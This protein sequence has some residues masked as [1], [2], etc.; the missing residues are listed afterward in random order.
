[1]QSAQLLPDRRLVARQL[2]GEVEHL[3]GGHEADAGDE[4]QHEQ[5]R[6]RDGK[7]ENLHAR[8]KL[9]RGYGAGGALLPKKQLLGAPWRVAFALQADG[10]VLR[11]DI[12]WNKLNP[13]PESVS[14]RCTHAHE[15]LFQLT[16]SVR[17]S[18]QRRTVKRPSACCRRARHWL[19][20][21]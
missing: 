3:R 14:D 21:S 10:W 6:E 4:C 18:R 7:G 9:T 17:Y 20:T 15:Y 8:K 2:G 13:M 11:H 16:R 19:A 5:Y 12:V 1:M